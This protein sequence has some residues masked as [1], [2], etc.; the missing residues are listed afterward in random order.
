MRKNKMRLLVA[1]ALVCGA[2]AGCGKS[3]NSGDYFSQDSINNISNTMPGAANTE[4]VEANSSS[5]VDVPAYTMP[6]TKKDVLPVQIAYYDAETKELIKIDKY[7]QKDPKAFALINLFPEQYIAETYMPSSD[8]TSQRVLSK[9]KQYEYTDGKITNII[10]TAY[11]GTSDQQIE[12][13]NQYTYEYDDK[14]LPIKKIDAYYDDSTQQFVA[15]DNTYYTYNDDG[16]LKS[17]SYTQKNVG[18]TITYKTEY[19][20]NTN[21]KPIQAIDYVNDQESGDTELGYNKDGSLAYWKT[22][23]P[24]NDNDTSRTNYYYDSK[25]YLR[26]LHM[27]ELNTYSMKMEETRIGVVL[28]GDNEQ[29]LG[30]YEQ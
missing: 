3:G 23:N 10:E 2:I 25:G 27:Y 4:D 16:T 21:G 20:Y 22:V 12:Y 30:K 9:S 6:Q 11:D 29:Y 28:Y 1:I 17:T 5:A 19:A 8:N 14:G 13:K 15:E 18:A 26:E 7:E 24:E